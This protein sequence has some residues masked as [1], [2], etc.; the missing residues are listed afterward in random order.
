MTKSGQYTK[1]LRIFV[2]PEMHAYIQAIAERN[3]L[4]INDAARQALRDYI[5][6][7][8]IPGSKSRF[9]RVLLAALEARQALVLAEMRHITKLILAALV[10]YITHTGLPLEDTINRITELARHPAMDR[11][12]KGMRANIDA[13]DWKPRDKS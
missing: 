7:Q 12:V 11:M 8:D 5:D 2:T 10:A 1:E 13:K 3:H 9:S 4:T 6:A